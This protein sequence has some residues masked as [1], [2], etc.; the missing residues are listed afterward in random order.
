MKKMNKKLFLVFVS[1][2]ILILVGCGIATI[3]Y[4]EESIDAGSDSVT[5]VSG[6]FTSADD[7]LDL[8][9]TGTGP[10]LMLFYVLSDNSTIP[11]SSIISSFSTTYINKPYGKI[12]SPSLSAPILLT[13]TSG[14]IYELFAF[15]DVNQTLFTAPDYITVADDPNNCSLEFTLTLEG[16]TT[17]GYDLGLSDTTDYGYTPQ[18][19]NNLTR[20]NGENFLASTSEMAD[21]TDYAAVSTSDI[22]DSTYYCHV[23]AAMCVAEGSFNNIFW[24][25]LTY[26]GSLSL[27]T[28]TT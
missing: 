4:L 11:Y 1:F 8:I 5:S 16:D 6:E 9:T 14:S 19:T 12:I 13:V 3:F 25:E 24:T 28:T 22:I 26:L 2:C 18:T 10:S 15:S 23:F 21:V 17:S 20:Y 27:T 7:D